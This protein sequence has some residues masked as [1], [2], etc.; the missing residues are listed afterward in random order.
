MGTLIFEYAEGVTPAAQAKVDTLIAKIPSLAVEE[1]KTVG[2]FLLPVP[3]GSQVSQDGKAIST[4]FF[5][6]SEESN[7]P[8][9]SG[10]S[11]I[12]ISVQAIR[13]EMKA[14]GLDGHVGGLAGLFGDLIGVF[15]A[16]NG[17]LLYSTVGVVFTVMVR[18]R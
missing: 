3:V 16:I 6:D 13:N 17:S 5:F 8:F 9:A 2:D 15:S 4:L 12:A 14:E 7:K 10:K 18:T 11:P 1:G